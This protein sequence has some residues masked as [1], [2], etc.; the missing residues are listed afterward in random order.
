MT[1]QS[2]HPRIVI[3]ALR[4]GSGKT[5]ISLG[6]LASWAKGGHAVAPF[7]KGPDFIDPSWLSLA[8]RRTC[9][10]LDPFMMTN[11]QIRHA[12]HV[13]SEG[14]DVSLIEG[15]RG[16]YDGLDLEGGCSTA[17]LGKL[18]RCPVVLIVDVTMTTRTAAA[19]VM[20]CQHFDPELQIG[21]VILNRVA[22]PRQEALVRASIEHYCGIPILGSVPRLKK[23]V[24]PERHMGL[25]PHYETEQAEYAI[26]WARSMVEKHL[27]LDALWALA[28]KA[29]P[30]EKKGLGKDEAGAE[31]VTDS[32]LRIG[33]IRDR[34]F[35]FYYPENLDQLK[36]LGAEI[37]EIDAITARHLPDLDALYVGGGFPE[38]QAEALAANRTFRASLK[39]RIEEGLP[40]YAE[41]GG[42]MYMGEHLTIKGRTYPMVGAFPVD[43]EH[44][45]RPQGHGYTVL[46]VVEENPY[47]SVGEILKGHEF[48]YSRPLSHSHPSFRTIFKVHR[49]RGLDGEVDGLCRKNVLATYTHLHSGGQPSWARNFIRTALHFREKM[50]RQPLMEK[51]D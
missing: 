33:L 3:S 9:H 30:F 36:N 19:L 12:F 8:G 16:L 1:M 2:R 50:N 44:K 32:R 43:F 46:E 37:I 42:L 15:N 40:V 39:A 41:C 29:E 14:A 23:N 47:F 6:L 28:S 49:G 48:H 24:I 35:W 4:G 45:K 25:I 34:A 27:H 13:Y 21:G 51:R 18:L 20:G 22:G 10:N 31:R 26:T 5:I 11:E 7:K 17:E 38:I